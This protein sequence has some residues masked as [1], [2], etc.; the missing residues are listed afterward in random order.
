MKSTTPTDLRGLTYNE[1]VKAAYFEVLKQTTS[2]LATLPDDPHRYSLI[3]EDKLPIIEGTIVHEFINPLLYMRLE[4]HKD[5]KLAINFGCD[6]QPGFMEYEPLAGTFLRILYKVTMAIN[7]AINIE[8]CI[9]TDYIV[10]EC[11]EFY[12]FLEEGG[13]KN[14]TFHLIKHKPKAIKRKLQKVA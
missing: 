10:T 3:R 11:S 12:E 7:T 8:D 13:L 9:K 1:C 5:D 14:H 2:L 4:C 6:S